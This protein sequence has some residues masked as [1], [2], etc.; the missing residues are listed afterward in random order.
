MIES[1]ADT[2]QTLHGHNITVIRLGNIY[3]PE[4]KVR[5]TR[6][7]MSR[8][9]QYISAALNHGTISVTNPDETH[10]WTFA[11]DVGRAVHALLQAETWNFPLYNVASAETMTNIEVAQLVQRLIPNTEVV[12]SDDHAAS[13]PRQ[14]Y[15]VSSRLL[16]DVGFNGWTPFLIGLTQIIRSAQPE[17]SS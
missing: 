8:V 4:E 10:D 17:Q 12:K 3:G 2:L 14:G 1:L 11:P 7:R 13:H 15:L 6:P 9:G 16:Q 5:D